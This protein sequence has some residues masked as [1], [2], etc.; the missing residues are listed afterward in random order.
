MV[1]GIIAR[2]G[3]YH[4]GRFHHLLY[5]LVFASAILSMFLEPALSLGCTLLCLSIMPFI[6]AKSFLHPFVAG[7]GLVG[8][9]LYVVAKA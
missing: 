7:I 4:F 6:K 3:K 2:L 8:W 1:V 5:F 9:I